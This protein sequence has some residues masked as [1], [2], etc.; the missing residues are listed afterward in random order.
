MISRTVDSLTSQYPKAAEYCRKRIDV[1]FN[2]SDGKNIAVFLISGIAAGIFAG[3][4]N[5][6]V[7]FAALGLTVILRAS[8]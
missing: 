4:P 5:D 7:K 3:S 6:I 1:F 2:T 8:S